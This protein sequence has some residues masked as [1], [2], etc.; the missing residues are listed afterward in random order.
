M[1]ARTQIAVLDHNSG[2]NRNQAVT[3]EGRLRHKSQ[4]SKVTEQH[5][6]KKI[7]GRKDKGYI[8]EILDEVR[9]GDKDQWQC[10]GTK[11]R[12]IAKRTIPVQRLFY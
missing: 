8:E 1:V 10:G 11:K 4:W 7:M 5:V 12:S 6:P 2:L 9:S 3:K